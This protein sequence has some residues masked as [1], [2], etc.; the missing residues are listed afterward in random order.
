MAEYKCECGKV[1]K[2]KAGLRAHKRHCKFVAGVVP[3]LAVIKEVAEKIEEKVAEPNAYKAP[4]V[5]TVLGRP[6]V[7]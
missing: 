5:L 2:T 4:V 1:C 3:G 6:V 7:K